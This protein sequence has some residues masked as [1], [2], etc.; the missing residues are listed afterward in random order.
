MRRARRW[1]IYG[2]RLYFSEK[3][4]PAAHVCPLF[5]SQKSPLSS[6]LA[7]LGAQ[8]MMSRDK[9]KLY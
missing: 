2:R 7:F 5:Y 3:S 6:R 9:L 4:P 8:K 1:L